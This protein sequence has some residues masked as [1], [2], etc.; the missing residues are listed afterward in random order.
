V[1]GY[2]ITALLV[3]SEGT[4][5][6][7]GDLTLRLVPMPPHVMTLLILFDDVH[8]SGQ[9]V[10]QIIAQ[11][12]VP[13]CI[14]LLDAATLSAVRAAGNPIDARA[15][16]MLLLELDGHEADVERDAQRI[17]DI[18]AELSVIDLLA[19]QDASQRDRLWA[20]RREMSPAVRR[21]SKF[22][23]SEDVVVPRQSIGELLTRVEAST[24]RLNVRSLTY[25]HA[26]DGNLHVNFLWDD[27]AEVARVEQAIEQ[28]F[29]D[30]IALR[31]TLS[32]EHGIGVLKAPYL[33]FE[34][35]QDLISL[36]R[37]LKAVFDPKGLLNPGKIFSTHHGAC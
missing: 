14:E 7:L 23:L 31:G 1:T 29:R 27:E 36:Q 15:N 17:A 11:G 13:R 33:H 37:E 24:Q 26:G 32:G 10:Q 34:Q 28:L 20:A 21:L 8:R 9:C 4:L 25:G 35:N 19:A 16:A 12:I 30:V 2:D 5:A 22:K 6:V 3:G 18:G